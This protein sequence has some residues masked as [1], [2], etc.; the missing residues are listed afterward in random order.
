MAP[1]CASQARLQAAFNRV[2]AKAGVKGSR[3][4]FGTLK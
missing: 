1:V 3:E 2:L 4:N